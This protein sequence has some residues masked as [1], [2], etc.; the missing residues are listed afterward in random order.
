MRISPNHP[1]LRLV[2][3]AC[4]AISGWCIVQGSR[5]TVNSPSVALMIAGVEVLGLILLAIGL[6]FWQIGIDKRAGIV[7]DTKGLLLNLG[8]SAAFIAWEN[9]ERVGVS[10]YRSSVLSLGSHHQL[11]IRLRNTD[12]YVQSYEERLPA[13]R[14]LIARSLRLLQSTLRPLQRHSDQPIASQL[15]QYRSETGYDVLVPEAL[16][17]GRASAFAELLDTYRLRLSERAVLGTFYPLR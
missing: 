14:G 11:G 8:H 1:R 9:I 10:S 5:L 3:L 6:A 16:L 7:F 4:W 12:A 2:A 17:G 15:A 13:A